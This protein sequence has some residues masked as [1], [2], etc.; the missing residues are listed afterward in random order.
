MRVAEFLRAVPAIVFAI[1]LDAVITFSS[2]SGLR[3][4]GF[5]PDQLVGQSIFDIYPD[6]TDFSQE[7]VR[8]IAGEEFRLQTT[9]GDRIFDTQYT[10]LFDRRGVLEGSLGIAVDITELVHNQRSLQQMAL[11]DAV[12]G[13]ASRA[14]VETLLDTLLTGTHTVSVLLVDVDGFRDVNDTHGHAVGDDVL[15]QIG[16]R[17]RDSLPAYSI[18]GRFGGDQFAVAIQETDNRSI[19]RHADNLLNQISRPLQVD[20]MVDGAPAYAE[21]RLSA[22]IGISVADNYNGPTTSSLLSRADSASHVAKRSG[23]GSY[24]FYSADHD[25]SARRL[26]LSTR[27]RHAIES[28][29]ITTEFQPVVRLQDRSIA[30]F[31]ALARWTDPILGK[32]CPSEFIALIEASPLIDD[33]FDAVLHQ[34]LSAALA[35]QPE[36][37]DRPPV[38]VSVNLSA[39]QLRNPELPGLIL[40]AVS[41]VGLPTDLLT[42]ELTETAILE[43]DPTTDRALHV[44]RDAGIGFHVDD[45]GVGYSNL[46]RL[47]ELIAKGL[48]RSVKIDRRLVQPLPDDGAHALLNAL[49][50]MTHALGLDVIAEGVET[51]AQLDALTG[52]GYDYVQGWLFHRSMPAHDARK[53]IIG[54]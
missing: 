36:S 29:D 21:L 42:L 24:S 22:S 49:R 17:V 31:E 8:A 35:W 47:G 50:S 23:G 19:A 40:R 54:R 32:V 26:S 38:W 34:A 43:P 28:G 16:A 13:L 18:V 1:D 25:R 9:L 30:G 12:T 4:L 3:P 33:L 27:I 51:E 10:P 45:F 37:D 41:E 20:V 46:A 48:L 11:S 15:R 14:H 7:F 5:E 52:L 44:L 39:R 53:L 6:R 2:G